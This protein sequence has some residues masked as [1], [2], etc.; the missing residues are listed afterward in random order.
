MLTKKESK[1]IKHKIKREVSAAEESVTNALWS[2]HCSYKSSKNWFDLFNT[3]G[4]RVILGE[5][6]GLID[7]GDGF[8]IKLGIDS[9]NHSSALNP[10]VG[11]ATGV[12]GIIRD[13]ISQGCKPIA[14]LDCLRF[15]DPSSAQ[16]RELL[17][18]VIL[19]KT[20]FSNFIGVPN[21][22]SNLAFSD[23]FE[24]N[25]LVN[26]M[27]VGVAKQK[28]IIPLIASNPEDLLVLYGASTGLETI[29]VTTSKDP[30]KNK[31]KSQVQKGDPSTAKQLINATLELRDKELLN[32][33]H[34]LARGG[35]SCAALKMAERGKNGITIDLLKVPLS[36]PEMTGGEILTSES[37]ERMLAVIK[38]E[39]KDKVLEILSK[40]DFKTSVIGTVT[41]GNTFIAHKNESLET[42]LPVD[43]IINGVPEQ[44]RKVLRDRSKINYSKRITKSQDHPL[45]EI[46]TSYNQ[47]SHT[48]LY[49]LKGKK[50]KRIISSGQDGGVI[51][52]PNNKLLSITTG[53]NSYLISQDIK[54]GAALST[55]GVIRS[56][57]SSGAT[58]IGMINSLNAGNP[59]KAG[60]YTEFVNVLKGVAEV[61]H[62]MNIPVV[63]GH[64]SWNNF[65][66]EKEKFLTS[67]F[68]GVAG[69]IDKIK[70]HI[71]NMLRDE[72]GKIYLIGPDDGFLAGSEYYR[73]YGGDGG[74]ITVDFGLELQ[75]KELLQLLRPFIISCVDIGRGGLLTTLA[76]WSIQSDI[77]LNY[78]YES[79]DLSF[80]WG[81]HGPRYLIQIPKDQE[82][83]CLMECDKFK[84]EL[85]IT[86]IAQIIKE[87][88]FELSDG[89][90]WELSNL[91]KLWEYP[92]EKESIK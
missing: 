35:L 84:T 66:K 79:E 87:K 75:A 30:D 74:E 38:P 70:D 80:S 88:K 3:E 17:D 21:M 20:S 15:G 81:E 29:S 43:F 64:V 44:K 73:R 91:K 27:G 54:D 23:E 61:S 53:G 78:F 12:G 83:K 9:S 34:D 59:D 45:I 42:N 60:S 76:K 14:L 48:P 7:V 51:K 2:E 6:E 71:P 68:I 33:L 72:P 65:G 36:I 92:F 67:S 86:P 16:Q 40:Y 77:G 39:N 1:A 82:M 10:Y 85:E 22:G 24:N 28:D 19:G 25:P 57:I 5:G 11:A 41:E 46:L 4:P 37:Q 31:Q 63:G 56:V 47:S 89:N 69:L 32:G 13:I 18:H 49:K 55:L 50:E 90:S 52:L 58:P 62:K 8:V 26:I